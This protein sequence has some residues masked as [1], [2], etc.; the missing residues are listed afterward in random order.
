MSKTWNAGQEQHNRDV[1]NASDESGI[2]LLSNERNA[3]KLSRIVKEQKGSQTSFESY[4]FDFQSEQLLNTCDLFL[5]S[6]CLALTLLLAF[7]EEPDWQYWICF[8]LVFL[9]LVLTS[10]L[11]RDFLNIFSLLPQPHFF[12]H[13]R[14]LLQ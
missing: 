14:E 6:A 1:V 9:S 2:N 3:Y 12:L 13:S 10:I 4:M 8:E 11:R 7:Q 5:Q